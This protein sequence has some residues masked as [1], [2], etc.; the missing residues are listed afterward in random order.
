MGSDLLMFVG[1]SGGCV[2]LRAG[3]QFPVDSVLGNGSS[4][5]FPQEPK[6]FFTKQVVMALGSKIL[7]GDTVFHKARNFMR[8]AGGVHP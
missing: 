2:G 5:G 6:I 4:R 7:N 3:P 1:G 8:N